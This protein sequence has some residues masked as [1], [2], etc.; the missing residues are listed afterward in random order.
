M[1]MVVIAAG[2][3]DDKLDVQDF[4]SNITILAVPLKKRVKWSLLLLYCIITVVGGVGAPLLQRLYYMH[5][6]TH[7]WLSSLLQSVGV[8]I[9]LPPLT[10]LY[11]RNLIT[12]KLSSKVFLIDTKL[13]LPSAAIGIL[14]GLDNYMYSSGLSYIPVSTSSLLFS[15]QL[16]FTALF[17]FLLVKQK[18]TFYSLNSVAV[19]TFGAIVL[20]HHTNADRPPGVSEENYLV[21]FF[22][23]LGGAA[24][25]GLCLPLI[26]LACSKSRK[27]L[28]SLMVLQFQ[29]VLS[30]FA[31]FVS[32]VGMLVNNDFRIIRQEAQNFTVGERKY[33]V[34]LVASA[35]LWQLTG[36]GIMCTINCTS[37]LFAGILTSVLLPFTELAAIVAFQEKFTVEKGFSLALC[38]WGFTSYFIGEYKKTDKTHNPDGI[39]DRLLDTEC[40]R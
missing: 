23:T 13:I 20:A 38:L 18:F 17:A 40:Q 25:S 12:D 1:S 19:M 35:I 26:E 33:Y 6:G 4:K 11:L 22:F 7:K 2:D 34:I 32:I 16:A 28:D 8:V 21:G 27:P 37:S 39:K 30:L 31:A 10:F 3:G 24:L 29:F 9:L 14:F 15:T 36:I 5:G